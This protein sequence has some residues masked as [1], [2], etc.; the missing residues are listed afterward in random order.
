M[1]DASFKVKKSLIIRPVASP[2]LSIQGEV[3]YDSVLD[4]LQVRGASTTDT[5][6]SVNK[7]QDILNKTRI[8]VDNLDLNG[9]TIASTDVDGN[10][11]LDPNGDGKILVAADIDVQS[12]GALKIGE[13]VGANTITIGGATSTIS[14][15]GTVNASISGNAA[16]FTGSLSGDVTGTQGSTAISASVVT[17]KLITGFVSGAG[18]VAATDTI[19]QAINKLDGNVGTKLDAS[20]FSDAGVT[21]KLI[22]GFTSGAG[23][24]AATDTILQAINK[25]D[26]NVGT[27]LNSSA[28]SD[29]GVT[30]K[31]I[32]GFVSG[33][34]VVAATDTILQA[35]NKLDGNIAAKQDAI[36]GALTLTEIV[37]PANPAAGALKIY[38][39]SDDKVYKL[40]SAGVE[41]E[42]G[43]GG[44]GSTTITVTAGENLSQY[45]AV[46]ISK[47]N[48]AG[49][50][51]RTAGSAYKLDPTND[52]RMNFIGFATAAISSSAT[53]NIQVVGELSGFS[54][55][56]EGEPVY[57]SVTSAG[58]YQVAAPN[59]AGQWIVPIGTATS[60]TK[61]S[62]NGAG[63]LDAI[64]VGDD[65][66]G[67]FSMSNNQSSAAS[68]T[69]LSFSG[70]AFRGAVVQYTVY[71][72]HSGVYEGS[73]VGTLY[74]GYR[75]NAADWK[76]DDIANGD[77]VGVTFTIT[78]AGQ[79]Q[80][81]STNL[82]GSQTSFVMK[83]N[84]WTLPV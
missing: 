3:A 37:T 20:A 67:T 27:K 82:S 24:V 33:A 78:A 48:A 12:A 74:L 47:G 18:T 56:T 42:I 25:L 11:I 84:Y 65:T 52:N 34:G 73:Q 39:K 23:T 44:G 55:L 64:Y 22:T 28:F 49:D 14:M 80:Y 5:L 54:G 43:T 19:L 38:A 68:I 50:T 32:T 59:T 75:T 57:G 45:D 72:Y 40:T 66:Q 29:A 41:T 35:I 58:G 62:V 60:A 81:T 4:A 77:L 15:P 69:N 21:G 36:T 13:S 7:A 1:A 51:G 16:G 17:G 70:S 10:I 9:N 79:V 31:L 53:G 71:R 83:W 8:T 30:G 63:G 2:T 26:G 61:I 46:Y 76:I 6:L